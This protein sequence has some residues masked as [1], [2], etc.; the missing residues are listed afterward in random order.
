MSQVVKVQEDEE[1]NQFIEFP[2]DMLEQVGW[3]EGDTITWTQGQNNSWV[4][5]KKE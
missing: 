5:S 2:P 3:Q 1:G 4:L